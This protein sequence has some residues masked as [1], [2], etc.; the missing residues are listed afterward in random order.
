[1][2]EERRPTSDG[3]GRGTGPGGESPVE[4]LLREAMAA[5]AVR[6]T[7]QDLRPADP[8]SGP[9][10]RRRPAYLVSLPLMGL[11]AA[12]VIGVLTVPGD[13]LADKGDDAP[14]A[15]MSTS[16]DPSRDPDPRSPTDGPTDVLGRPAGAPA[17]G[18]SQ[19][20]DDASGTPAP[21]TSGSSGGQG[22]GSTR[23]GTGAA[24]PQPDGTAA[25]T[26]AA[27]DPPAGNGGV[28][29]SPQGIE[30][31]FDG[32]AGR[33]AM[34]GAGP[35]TF[36]VTWH[37]TTEITYGKVAPVVAVRSLAD[38]DG[39]GRSLRGRLQREDEGG[40]WTD[41]PLT[42]ASGNY[43]A[44]GDEAAFPLAPGASR[45][46]RYRLDP[47]IDSGEGTLL[48]EALALTPAT[49]QRLVEASVLTALR[50]SKA[51]AA[52]RMAP[53]FT[54]KLL[55]DFT[56][57]GRRAATFTLTVRNPGAA[58]LASVFP[59]VL[60]SG[61]EAGS[62][63]MVQ[64]GYGTEGRRSL[65]V[66]RNQA[67]RGVVDTSLLERLVRPHESTTFSFWLSVPEGWNSDPESFAAVVGAT[68]DGQEAAPV[69]IYPSMAIAGR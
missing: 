41:V 39:D 33:E 5:R 62:Q 28:V 24:S 3:A 40:A 69:V 64:A 59:T 37:N 23:P 6:I 21:G 52:A 22:P 43:L 2:S 7:A 65:P 68:G 14:A 8:P 19:G 35:V 12:T 48:I 26:R 38:A 13:T 49:P 53:E 44:S 32:L 25:A 56:E 63:I 50:L 47:S 31:S 34:V 30:L 10:I 4:R 45:T 27:G 55:E 51:P 16:A 58:P 18:A 11:A 66:T 42:E 36:T 15:T 54:V 57:P 20:P 1:M 17:Q 67:G 60:L 61:T 46:V 9:R 29:R